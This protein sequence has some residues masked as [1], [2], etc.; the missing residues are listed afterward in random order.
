MR[1]FSV[2]VDKHMHRYCIN[3]YTVLLSGASY[4]TFA[5]TVSL[6]TN[7]PIK[8]ALFE[9]ES[10]RVLEHLCSQQTISLCIAA[11]LMTH[12]AS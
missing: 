2:G 8:D 1:I 7:L 11:T 5:T 4:N 6:I 3:L 10:S 12:W 9:P